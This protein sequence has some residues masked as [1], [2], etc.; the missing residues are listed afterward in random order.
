MTDREKLTEA[1]AR[2]IYDD[3]EGPIADQDFTR[4]MRQWEQAQKLATAALAAIEASGAVVVPVEATEGMERAGGLALHR[5]SGAFGSA[6]ACY[7]AMIAASPY[8]KEPS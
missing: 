4:Q 8:A 7:A 6:G 3:L 1:M 2:V 5:C